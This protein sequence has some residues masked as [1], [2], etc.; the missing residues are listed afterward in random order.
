MSV[1]VMVLFAIW[2][3]SPS[4]GEIWTARVWQ[5]NCSSFMYVGK[6][7]RVLVLCSSDFYLHHILEE[8]EICMCVTNKLQFFY[9]CV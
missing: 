4:L 6:F 8:S 7:V 5:I 1:R 9:V 3:I 2:V